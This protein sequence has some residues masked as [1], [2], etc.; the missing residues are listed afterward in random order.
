MMQGIRNKDI[1][2]IILYQHK[3]MDKMLANLIQCQIEKILN[4]YIKKNPVTIR[5]V[6][7]E[8]I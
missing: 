7:W 5:K 8:M 2:M 3:H 1:I 6:G 4:T